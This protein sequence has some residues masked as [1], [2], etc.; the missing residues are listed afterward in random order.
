[1]QNFQVNS[2][3]K[4]NVNKEGVFIELEP[5]YIAALQALDGFS[6]INVIW[7][8]SDFDNEETRNILE[9]S[10]PYKNAPAVMGIFATRSPVRPNPIALTAVEVIHIDYEKGI[11]QIAYID[12]NDGTPILDIKPYTPSLDRVE[13]PGLP[14]WCSHWPKCLEQSGEFNWEDEFNF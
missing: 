13:T 1:M 14:E 5:K 3:G 2:I 7:W 6:H 8:F 9:A 4:I 11:I 10:K 12:A